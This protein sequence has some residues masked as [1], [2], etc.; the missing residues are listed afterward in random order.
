MTATADSAAG[1]AA[2][3]AETVTVCEAEVS[4]LRAGSGSPVMVLPK[5]NGHPP[6]RAFASHLAGSFA[7][8]YPHLPGF[9][10]TPDPAAWEWLTNVR[11]LAIVQL[12]LLD[13]LGLDRVSLVGVGFGGWVAAE[14]ATM[15][16]AGLN[17]LVLVN[18]MGIQPRNAYIYDQFLVSTEAYARTGFSDDAAF[19]QLYGHEP[20]YDQL[21]AWETDRAMTSRLAWKPYMYNPALPRLLAGVK[22]PSLV[23]AGDADRIVPFECAEAYV[24][25]LP[26]ATL[27]TMPACNHAIDAEHPAALAAA[28]ASFLNR[29]RR[30]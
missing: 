11:D 21:D 7:V 23:I 16:P 26:N 8:S 24:R 10:G 30:Q 25:A 5:D 15:H 4:L 20:E 2:W 3:T 6:G 29:N 28:V 9:H 1:T 12:Q 19:D 13:A 22:A 14:M 18:P 27:E 17:A